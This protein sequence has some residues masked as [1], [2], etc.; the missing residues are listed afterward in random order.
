MEA[1]H[2]AEKQRLSHREM[3]FPPHEKYGQ[4]ATILERQSMA[5]SKRK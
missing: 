5:L 4:F 2:A 1:V 3:P